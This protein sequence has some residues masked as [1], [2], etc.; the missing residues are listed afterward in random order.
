MTENSEQALLMI[1]WSKVWSPLVDDEL[2]ADTWRALELP[3]DYESNKVDYWSTFHAGSP[4]PPLP[5]VLHAAL[6]REGNK[7][8]E[9]WLRVMNY[10][11]LTFD[12]ARLPPDQLG[13][14]CEVY[15]CAIEEEERV[16]VEELRSR[17]LLPWCEL[18]RAR[19]SES[20]SGLLPLVEKFA[21]D[22]STTV[23]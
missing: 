6:G 8:R 11:G 12:E 13:A 3:G 18:A 9:D 2:R 15:A 22:L 10:L 4:E 19:L 16:L 5:L 23:L 17:Y 7:V 20:R 14:A 21:Q 1:A